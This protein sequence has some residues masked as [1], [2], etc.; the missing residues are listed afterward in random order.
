VYEMKKKI[1]KSRNPFALQAILRSGSG[2]HEK[3]GKEK[4]RHDRRKMKQS[5]IEFT[6]VV[7]RT[8]MK[9]LGQMKHAANASS[10]KSGKVVK[11][12]V[13]DMQNECLDDD[14]IREGLSELIEWAN[15]FRNSIGVIL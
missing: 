1:P 13:T 7:K 4:N 5:G 10:E 6:T 15:A 12:Y 11:Q 14:E 8:M 9:T 2:P 3:S